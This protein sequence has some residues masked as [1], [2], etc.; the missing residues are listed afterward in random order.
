MAPSTLELEIVRRTR[1]LWAGML[2]AVVIVFA[3]PGATSALELPALWLVG[4]CLVW[5]A[6]AMVVLIAALDENPELEAREQN[7]STVSTRPARWILKSRRR[8]AVA[9]LPTYLLELGAVVLVMSG[10]W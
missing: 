10:N 2:G 6:Y 7:R 9:M 3:I 8:R 4:P 5:H 1:H